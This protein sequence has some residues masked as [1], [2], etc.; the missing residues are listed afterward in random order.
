MLRL[1]G[2]LRTHAG[3]TLVELLV[4]LSIFTVVAAGLST[5]Y[6]SSHR[7]LD[8]ASAQAFVQ[9][10]GT[11]IEQEIRRQLLPAVAVMQ[12][13]PGAD[14]C[15][16]VAA[17]AA[18]A[19]QVTAAAA[20]RDPWLPQSVYRCLYAQQD[21]SPGPGLSPDSAPQ[22]Y[23]CNLADPSPGAS[24]LSDVIGSSCSGTKRSLMYQHQSYHVVGS[25]LGTQMAA[26]TGAGV[27]EAARLRVGNF[28]AQLVPAVT[29]L[30][31]CDPTLP[32][33][34]AGNALYVSF[35]LTDNTLFAA[36]AGVAGLRF[37]LTAA[38]RN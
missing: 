26:Q 21:G 17:P 36:Q 14:T 18:V 34:G 4:S 29:G 13:V 31:S 24:R 37:T 33:G 10:Q 30:D 32:P 15:A 19:F 7:A 23:V 3:L 22:I 20:A 38:L 27:L 5:L 8:V 11:L 9:R 2:C 35:D 1:P 28:C 25:K 12:A 16:G 6:L